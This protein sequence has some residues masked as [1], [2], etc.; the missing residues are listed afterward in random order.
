MNVQSRFQYKF[1]LKKST[2]VSINIGPWVL[3]LAKA[4]E[5]WWDKFEAL[6]D[7]LDERIVREVGEG[8]LALAHVTRIR[9]TEYSVSEARNNLST[10]EGFLDE[11]EDLVVGWG[12]TLSLGQVHYPREDFLV[13]ETVEWPSQTAHGSTKAEVGIR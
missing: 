3:D 7:N 9:L 13:C 8:E 12:L 2:R 5:I 1:Y 11:F 4:V 6:G 10:G